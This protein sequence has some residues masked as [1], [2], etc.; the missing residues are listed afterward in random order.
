MTEIGTRLQFFLYPI[1]LAHRKF[2][3]YL[4]FTRFHL[5]SFIDI[6]KNYFEL[7]NALPNKQSVASGPDKCYA[8]EPSAE[9]D[10]IDMNDRFKAIN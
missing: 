10:K 7:P 6:T 9:L 4:L 5:S 8:I 1:D 3:T 2:T